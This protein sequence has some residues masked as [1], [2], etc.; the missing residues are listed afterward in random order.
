[1]TTAL[2][3]P[4]LISRKLQVAGTYG[5]NMFGPQVWRTLAYFHFFAR[6][7]FRMASTCMYRAISPS[8]C[9]V[10]LCCMSVSIRSLL[11]RE[12]REIPR[13]YNLVGWTV[14]VWCGLRT[15][16]N[17]ERKHRTSLSAPKTKPSN[18]H[19]APV[20]TQRACPTL[21]RVR[22]P[23]LKIHPT[24][25]VVERPTWPGGCWRRQVHH[26]QKTNPQTGGYGCAHSIL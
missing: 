26:L 12:R 15:S 21:T 25:A 7:G 16:L 6:R 8:I 13:A 3:W 24:W 23:T 5:C 2:N 17:C 4:S 14:D 11:H 20:A 18:F 19:Q 9:L 10:V 22:H 1:M